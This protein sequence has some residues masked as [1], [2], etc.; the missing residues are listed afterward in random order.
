MFRKQNAVAA[1]TAY[2]TFTTTLSLV[3]STVSPSSTVT[4]VNSPLSE[5]DVMAVWVEPGFGRRL[6]LTPT[7]SV[8]DSVAFILTT[9]AVGYVV[10][11][12][13]LS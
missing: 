7:L 11:K 8:P 9:S 6:R 1:R 13:T 5:P 4:L 2:L 10:A 3:Y 12:F